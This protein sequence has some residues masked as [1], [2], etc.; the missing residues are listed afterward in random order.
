MSIYGRN[1]V[2]VFN[3]KRFSVSSFLDLKSGDLTVRNCK[4]RQSNFT[5]RAQVNAR[6]EVIVTVFTERG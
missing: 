2:G 4:H 6:M 3:V 5:I 1:A